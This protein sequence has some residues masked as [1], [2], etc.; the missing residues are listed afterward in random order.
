MSKIVRS[1]AVTGL[2]ALS[3][4][5]AVSSA[6]AGPYKLGATQVTLGRQ[7]SDVSAITPN[8][9]KQLR[10]L[11]IDGPLLN[12]LFLTAGLAPGDAMVRAPSKEKPT[13]KVR[14]GM[15][16]AE[17][18]EFVTDSV[19]AMNYQRVE[20]ARP[21]A[22]RYGGQPAVRFDLSARTP[23][24]LDVLGTALVAELE[25]K[26]YVILYLAPAEHYFQA[27]LPEVEQVMGSARPKA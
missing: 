21:R 16:S 19:A 1:L 4:C 10:V 25:G 8:R 15:T 6:P 2:L 23:A 12:T 27:T 13:P 11:S 20:S 7:W 9:V 22:A 26:L 3:A 24:G 18:M 5:T 17:R 14:T